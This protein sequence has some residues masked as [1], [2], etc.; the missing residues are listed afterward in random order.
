MNNKKI[1]IISII[2]C[3]IILTSL[4][5]TLFYYHNFESF[6]I[7]DINQQFM[8]SK[9]LIETGGLKYTNNLNS[10]NPSIF[11]IRGILIKDNIA[12][13][14]CFLGLILIYAHLINFTKFLLPLLNPLF[15]ICGGIFFYKL[16]SYFKLKKISK[17]TGLISFFFLAPLFLYSLLPYNNIISFSLFLITTYYLLKWSDTGNNK[18]I[19]ILSFL[20]GIHLWVRGVDLLFH[21]PLLG[22]IGIKKFKT[23]IKNKKSLLIGILLFLLLAIPLLV[24]N[25]TFYGDFS[26]PKNLEGK[27]ILNY[28]ELYN[29]QNT[30][31]NNVNTSTNLGNKIND[32]LNN[33]ILSINPLIFLFSI[34]GAVA[35]LKDKKYILIIILFML[36]IS[37]FL[38]YG[39]N[40]H[41]GDS[42]K[43]SVG[44]SFTRYISISWGILLFL[45]LISI[46]KIKNKN[47]LFLLLFI[48]ILIL[49]NLIISLFGSFG[50]YSFLDIS[51]HTQRNDR[52]YF[53]NKENDIIFT[54]LC[55]KYLY[56]S[57]NFAIYTSFPKKNRINQTTK[58]I[59]K[60][61]SDGKDIY[62]IHDTNL[63]YDHKFKF[64][65]QSF[66]KNNLYIQ[67]IFKFYKKI[68]VYKIENE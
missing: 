64:Y 30:T 58:L 45:S 23:I 8:F 22:Y 20:M 7:T 4:S 63:N 10:D 1:L 42:L 47:K 60:L 12:Y 40:T 32:L 13:P 2:L 36:I 33:H 25:N 49:T 14:T 66:S 16:L 3:F 44:A 65:K 46:N 5:Y 52:S 19:F 41:S 35:L 50:Y 37:Q 55:D 26:G 62:F 9:N 54:G 53:E 6:S 21:I 28:Y 51:R 15:L 31:N 34:L 67:K 11:G 18:I 68:E 38:L 29:N 57:A 39:I 59:I 24:I 61:L 27:Q 17:I 43:K 56:P 48:L